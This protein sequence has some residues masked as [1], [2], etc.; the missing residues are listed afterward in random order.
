VMW[1]PSRHLE[2][3]TAANWVSFNF[4]VSYSSCLGYS[5]INT[6][7]FKKFEWSEVW[8]RFVFYFVF[9]ALQL[10]LVS[11]YF[12]V[13]DSSFSMKGFFFFVK[14]T[15]LVPVEIE[16]VPGFC[17]LLSPCFRQKERKKGF[18]GPLIPVAGSISDHLSQAQFMNLISRTDI[19]PDFTSFLIQVISS[20]KIFNRL[21]LRSDFPY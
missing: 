20:E 2:S 6:L 15:N 5:L 21:I 11:G 17:S 1:G 12:V 4:N 13:E 7:K 19:S 8:L 10:F 16:L 9:F 3:L 18:R 14:G